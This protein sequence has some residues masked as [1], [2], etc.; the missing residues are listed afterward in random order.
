MSKNLADKLK[1]AGYKEG[2]DSLKKIVPTIEDNL[3]KQIEIWERLNSFS[4]E[5]ST[6][7]NCL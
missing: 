3:A 2:V 6:R 5:K 7:R 1:Q 4:K